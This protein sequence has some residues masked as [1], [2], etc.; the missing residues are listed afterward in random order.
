MADGVVYTY[1]SHPTG[2]TPSSIS[3]PAQQDSCPPCPRW[4]RTALGVGWAGNLALLGAV[5]M[6][7]VLVSQRPSQNP[8]PTAAMQS[9]QMSN[10]CEST[11]NTTTCNGSMEVFRSCLKEKLCESE[12]SS[13]GDSGCK[14]CPMRWTPHR[15]KCYWLSDGSK[16]W[17]RSRDDCTQRRSHLLVIQDQD[18]MMFIQNIIGDQNPVWIGLNITCPGKNCT[19]VDGSPLNQT[20]FTVS[21]PVDERS[22][23]ALKKNRIQPEICN[24][25]LK[26]ICQKEVVIL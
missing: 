2:S 8:Q 19:W 17:N 12:N 5:A 18:E 1:L 26:W 10:S 20:L 3:T 11:Q 6:L 15:D 21:G 4:H 9:A 7:V 13:A 23:A 24:T 25:D 16:Y 22:C 14:L